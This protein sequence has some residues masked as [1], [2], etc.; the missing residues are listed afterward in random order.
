MI[1]TILIILGAIIGIGV[2]GFLTAG[3]I[4]LVKMKII[5]S[6]T[7]KALQTGEKLIKVE[8]KKEKWKKK[9]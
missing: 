4:F 5:E 8:D 2:I 9:S 7:K 1:G 6:K 3:A